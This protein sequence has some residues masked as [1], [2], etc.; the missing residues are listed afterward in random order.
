MRAGRPRCAGHA[1][2]GFGGPRAAGHPEARCAPVLGVGSLAPGHPDARGTPVLSFG[3]PDARRALMHGVPPPPF[4]G[5]GILDV[6]GTPKH[7][8]LDLGCLMLWGRP[9]CW[10]ALPFLDLGRGGGEDAVP[11]AAP[12]LGAHVCPSGV[13]LW[14]CVPP[15]PASPSC[16]SCAPPARPCLCP[17]SRQL[18]RCPTPAQGLG[19]PA[20]CAALFLR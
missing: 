10:G 17:C 9:R 11:P 15:P 16:V 19:A 7:E 4:A 12:L 18:L 6:W 14:G 3:V 5:F 13:S 1:A 2:A 8:E 20:L